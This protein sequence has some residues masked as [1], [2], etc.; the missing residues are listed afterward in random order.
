VSGAQLIRAIAL[1]ND[2]VC[3]LG[4]AI[5]GSLYDYPWTRPP[6]I[7]IWAR[8]RRIGAAEARARRN[9][10]GLRI[11]AAP[12]RQHPRVSLCDGLGSARLR[13]GFSVR[14]GI[15]AALMARAGIK[16]DA[17]AIEGRFGL[18]QAFFRGEYDPNVL[19]DD[20]GSRFEGARRYRSSP[21]RR[22]GRHATIRCVIELHDMHALEA[23]SV[24]NVHSMSDARTSSSA[25]P[26]KCDAGLSAAWM[27]SPAC[28]SPARLRWCT[29]A[30]RCPRTPPP[31]CAHPPCSTSQ[32]A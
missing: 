1:G 11:D 7:G 14:N 12:D 16:G 18:F 6:I 4:L 3:R 25:S 15:T 13:D 20:L 22:R 9:R 32:G 23:G 8:P 31:R 17:T 24:E 28:R 30:C 5:R 29:A 27:R 2:I 19:T 10:V 26:P 21:G